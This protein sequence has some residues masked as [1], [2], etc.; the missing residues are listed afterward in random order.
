MAD[1]IREQLADERA[2][3]AAEDGERARRV[4][5]RLA[6]WT[7]PRL[8]AVING[9]GVVLHTN[10]GR[11]PI[12]RAAATAAADVA[13]GYSNLELDLESGRRGDRYALVAPLLTRLTAAE[14]A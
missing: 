10:L 3:A 4:A 6:G 7:A 8:R 9:T 12:S 1:A 13:A 5:A 2:G 14:A 11:A